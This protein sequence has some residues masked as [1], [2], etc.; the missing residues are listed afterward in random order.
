MFALVVVFAAAVPAAA[1]TS[2]LIEDDLTKPGGAFDTGSGGEVARL[3]FGRQGMKVTA[4]EAGNGVF[5]TPAV[6]A[7]EDALLNS[8]IEFKVKAGKKTAIGAF[9]RRTEADE[10][11]YRVSDGFLVFIDGKQFSQ[12]EPNEDGQFTIDPGSPFKVKKYKPGKFNT[13][14]MEC[15]KNSIEGFGLDLTVYVNG[16]RVSTSAESRAAQFGRIGIYLEGLDDTRAKATF[17]DLTMEELPP[18]T[19]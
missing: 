17:K 8:A 18:P 19:S 16:E 2:T 6:N 3:A 12:F 5:L 15:A 13:I 4:A 7:S 11:G 1:Q 14:R 10:S 9:C